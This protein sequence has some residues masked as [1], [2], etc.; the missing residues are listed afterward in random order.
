M[1]RIT[2]SEMES[3]IQVAAEATAKEYLDKDLAAIVQAKVDEALQGREGE[4]GAA[5]VPAK[6]FDEQEP[7]KSPDDVE[8]GSRFACYVRAL[9]LAKN[10]S[11]KA[12][13]IARAWGRIDVAEAIDRSEEKALSTDIPGAGGFLVPT[14]FS[15]EVIE[16]LRASGVV[17]GLGPTVIPM[18]S[19]TIKMPKITTGSAAQYIGENVNAPKTELTTGQIHMT[20]KKLAAIVPISNDLIR[21]AAPAADT[22]VR[23][24]II[25]ALTAREDLAFIRDDG[26]NGKPKGIK[27]WIH[28]DNKFVANTTVNLQNVT[29]DLGKCMQLLMDAEI[30]L[31]I[32]QG[33]TGAIDV[34]AGWMLNPQQWRYLT[35][36]QT[37]LGTHAFRDEM[38]RGT[39]WGYPYRVTTQVESTTVYFGAFAHAMIGESLG[40]TV[41]ASESAAY[42]DGNSVV[43]AFSL[44]QTVIR[45]LAEHDFALRHDKAFALIT[46]VTW[47]A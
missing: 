19:G 7:Q 41:D 22:V 25:R 46:S 42:H 17:R 3:R 21:Y 39:L 10:D 18:A 32:G 9:A 45:V 47:G 33:G 35:T 37:G 29:N 16:L 20:F 40:L 27:N 38:L 12:A 14:E 11:S 6:L 36:I 8:L 43:A 34:R 24:D 44:D 31:V 28:N 13:Q 4:G 30:N 1:E 23:D 15:A 2:E 5:V 26:T